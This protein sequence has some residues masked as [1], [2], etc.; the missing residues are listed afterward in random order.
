VTEPSPAAEPLTYVT[1]FQS[2]RQFVTERHGEA[3]WQELRAALR[4]RHG[5]EL[6]AA[7]EANSW[8]P[9][10]AFTTALNVGRELFG[11]PDFHFKHGWAAAEYEMSWMHRIALRFKTPLWLMERGAAFWRDAH[12]TGRWVIDGRKG[13]LRGELHEFGVVDAAY[14]ESLRAWI[15]H[16]CLM[17]GASRMFVAERAC[18]ARGAEACVFE[19]T[20]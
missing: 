3:G 18:R 5:L 19:G 14:C 20:W 11:P 4:E 12:T 13:W 2:T 15:L 8:L 1:A 17:T 6:P 10:I 16:S 7:F 9:T